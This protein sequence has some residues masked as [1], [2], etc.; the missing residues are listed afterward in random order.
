MKRSSSRFKRDVI[1]PSRTA[2]NVA[3]TRVDKRVKLVRKIKAKA[4]TV[5]NMLNTLDEHGYI[6]TWSS[7]I[8]FNNLDTPTLDVI[9]SNRVDIN[10]ITKTK[11]MSVLT[12]IDKELTNFTNR[13]TST[14]KGI[15]GMKDVERQ[16]IEEFTDEEFANSLSTDELDQLYEVFNSDDYK[17]LTEGG[18]YSSTEILEFNTTAVEDISYQKDYLKYIANHSDSNPDMKTRQAFKNIY[19]K[20]LQQQIRGKR[21]TSKKRKKIGR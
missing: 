19:N 3:R 14:V 9:K 17:Y 15:Q 1:A 2:S 16:V 20:Y 4:S 11:T 21:R 10:K 8:L 5:N 12:K 18:Q 13:K 7:K 6:G